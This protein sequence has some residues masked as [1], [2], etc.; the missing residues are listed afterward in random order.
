MVNGGLT[1]PHSVV[2]TIVEFVINFFD[3][4]VARLSHRRATELRHDGGAWPLAF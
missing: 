4:T 1:S 2:G 3:I